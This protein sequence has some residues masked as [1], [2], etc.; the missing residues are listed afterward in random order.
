MGAQ[1]TRDLRVGARPVAFQIRH[2]M[3]DESGAHPL[4]RQRD[5]LVDQAGD[6]PSRGHVD[7]DWPAFGMQGVQP[8][9]REALH[10]LRARLRHRRRRAE[11]GQRQPR[12]DDG[13]ERQHPAH[14]PLRQPVG[15]GAEPKQ[16]AT[17]RNHQHAR[18]TRLHAH[19]PQQP[20]RRSVHRERQ[21]APQHIH[22][23]SGPRQRPRQTR[24]Q[25]QRP[26]RRRQPEPH[27]EEHEQ[28]QPRRRRERG[29]D[30]GTHE[31]RSARRR[32]QHRE[33]PGEETAGMAAPR[34]EPLPCPRQPRADLEHARQVQPDH[35]QHPRHHG[36]ELGRLELEPPPRRRPGRPR[37]Q[38]RPAQRRKGQQHARGVRRRVP[39]HPAAPAPDMRAIPTAFIARPGRRTASGSGSA[40]P[41]TP[42]AAPSRMACLPPPARARR[43]RQGA[44]LPPG[45]T[46]HDHAPQLRSGLNT[47]PGFSAISTT[48]GRTRTRCGAAA[49]IMPDADGKN[50]ASRTVAAESPSPASDSVP[51]GP[52]AAANGAGRGEREASNTLAWEDGAIVPSGRSS[53]NRASSGTQIFSQTSQFAAASM[54]TAPG[55][56]VTSSAAA[57]GR[58]SR[59]SSA[60]LP[61]A[62]PASAS[63]SDPLSPAGHVDLRRRARIAR[64]LPIGV[65]A[66]RNAQPQPD[67]EWL[68][69]L[70]PVRV[71]YQTRRHPLALH[72]R[73]LSAA[74]AGAAKTS[75]TS[76]ARITRPIYGRRGPK[77]HPPHAA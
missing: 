48:P 43:R 22:P 73:A 19:D 12:R 77:L 66:R 24:P 68:A 11:P 28:G 1:E 45:V 38:Q 35:E 37:R 56:A 44:L 7:E 15:P 30:G 60:A 63:R 55:P 74:H 27:R 54:C 70:D 49:S 40:R 13:D 65:P 25:R 50:Q 62:A 32:H 36:D 26:I 64:V 72:G 69:R 33:E 20:C 23:P 67:P 10:L 8:G 16:H 46:Q 59:T 17:R 39:T 6:A 9:A 57:P 21:R 31:R 5:A 75:R 61:A 58:Y 47:L 41:G 3:P 42:A 51:S 52:I 71:R 34:C 2:P 14:P 76:R 4:R 29:G 53:V 18:R